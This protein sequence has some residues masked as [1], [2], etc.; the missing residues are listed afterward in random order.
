MVTLTEA[1]AWV[2]SE[3]SFRTRETPG[4]QTPSWDLDL[5]GAGEIVLTD[6]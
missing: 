3:T 4:T 6:L 2:H 1:Y 5:A